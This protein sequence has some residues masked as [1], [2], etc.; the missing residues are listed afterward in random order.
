[1]EFKAVFRGHVAA[2]GAYD[3]VVLRVEARFVGQRGLAFVI[4]VGDSGSGKAGKGACYAVTHE[5][6]TRGVCL[7]DGSVAVHVH[8]ESGE[9]VALAVY[10]TECRVV[11]ALQAERAPQGVGFRQAAREKV[12]VYVCVGEIKHAHGDAAYLVVSY[13]YHSAVGGN[14]AHYGAFVY[15]AWHFGQ[16]AGKHPWVQAVQRVFFAAAQPQGGDCVGGHLSRNRK[17]SLALAYSRSRKRKP[18]PIMLAI[19]RKRSLGLRR[20]TIST[21]RNRV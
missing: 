13:A 4:D 10:E 20:V 15:V 18:M 14:Y 3:I 11:V 9:E 12:V 2:V 6:H 19:S 1:M 21:S 16:G 8:Y 7:Y 5:V 17:M